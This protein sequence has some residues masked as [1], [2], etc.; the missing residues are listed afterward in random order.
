MTLSY[1]NQ[2]IDLLCKSIGWFLYG[3][4]IGRERVIDNKYYFGELFNSI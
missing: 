3:R 1:I 4:D 2:S